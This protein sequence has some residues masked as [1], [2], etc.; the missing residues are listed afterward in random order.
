MCSHDPLD[1]C[2]CCVQV[3]VGIFWPSMMTMRAHYVP[4][5]LRST[6]INCFRIPLN[7]FVCIILYNVSAADEGCS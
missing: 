2:S 6:I 4:E 3:M 5:D 7:L 1:A